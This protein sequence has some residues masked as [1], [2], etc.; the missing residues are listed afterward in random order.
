MLGAK[1]MKRWWRCIVRHVDEAETIENEWFEDMCLDDDPQ[2]VIDHFNATREKHELERVLVAAISI[3]KDA[4]KP[5]TWQ[6]ASLV[7]ERGGYDRY[8][9]TVCGATGKRYG[10]NDFIT[11]DKKGNCK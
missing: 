11:P 3:S 8:R 9:C 1:D 2:L 5:H 10:L 4:P 6:K 7:T